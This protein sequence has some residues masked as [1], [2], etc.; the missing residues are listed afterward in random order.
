MATK[1]L[2]DNYFLDHVT[3]NPANPFEYTVTKP[4]K[5]FK[6]TRRMGSR[7]NIIAS[8]EI[9][10][11]S[12]INVPT[13]ARNAYQSAPLEVYDDHNKSPSMTTRYGSSLR[14]LRADRATVVALAGRS[15][16]PVIESAADY[17]STFR[18]KVGT[19]V[20]PTRK[21]VCNGNACEPGIH[22][23]LTLADAKNYFGW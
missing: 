17:D 22:F 19:S 14:K 16:S 8:L 13:Q 21:M 23:F 11:G 10:A 15:G 2:W 7:G 18:Y 4:L 9:P 1:N 20:R 5:V 6:S 3:K 12:R